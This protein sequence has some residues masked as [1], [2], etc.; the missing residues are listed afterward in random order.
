[1][2][3][4][5]D[6][7]LES[8]LSLQLQLRILDDC[9]ILYGLIHRVSGE[10]EGVTHARSDKARQGLETRQGKQATIP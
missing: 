8:L 9:S 6:G 4:I 1:M 10:V 7:V 2:L 3:G 5:D